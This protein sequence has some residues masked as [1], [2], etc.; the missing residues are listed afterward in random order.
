MRALVLLPLILGACGGGHANQPAA[1]PI[2]NQQ[3]APEKPAPATESSE[4]MPAPMRAM[5]AFTDRMCACADTACAQKVNEDMTA[6]AS[7]M[8]EDTKQP[9]QISEDEQKRYTEI[10]VRMGECM[11]QVMNAAP[12]STP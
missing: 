9:V 10:G 5:T 4:S 7:R 11:Q 12:G 2:G 6:W 8:A 1:E 3:P